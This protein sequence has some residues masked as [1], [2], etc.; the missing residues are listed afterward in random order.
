MTAAPMIA[1]TIPALM[2][3]LAASTKA[4]NMSK[5]AVKHSSPHRILII[6]AQVT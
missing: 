3:L 5:L 2:L 1:D 4:I 6:T